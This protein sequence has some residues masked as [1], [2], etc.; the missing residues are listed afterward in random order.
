MKN[1]VLGCI[2]SQMDGTEKVFGVSELQTLPEVYSYKENMCPVLDQGSAQ[3]CVPCTVSSYLNWKENLKDGSNKDNNIKLYEIYK[4][5]PNRG[6]GMT[7]KDALK[8]LN[9]E[10]VNSDA[11]LLKIKSYGRVMNPIMLKAAIVMNGPCFGALPV[12]SDKCDFW[13]NNF[14]DSFLGYHAIA[15]VGYN[16]EGVIIRN[17]WGKSFCE[18]GYTVIPYDDYD[19]ILELWTVM[20]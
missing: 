13:N 15:I 12:Y 20:S 18:K 17:S 9:K 6:D 10:G 14:N 2:P 5:R 16:E 11:G 8:F 1:L 7:F 3:I 19:K 4:S